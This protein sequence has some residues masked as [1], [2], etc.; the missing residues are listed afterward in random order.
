MSESKALTTP[1]V[2]VD[3]RLSENNAPR[4]CGHGDCGDD[5]DWYVLVWGVFS[6]YVCDGHHDWAIEQATPDTNP[7]QIEQESDGHWAVG[8]K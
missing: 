2:D 5:A 6:K 4:R 3:L 1:G 7:E 8:K